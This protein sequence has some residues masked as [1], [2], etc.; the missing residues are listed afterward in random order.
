M[1]RPNFLVIVGGDAGYVLDFSKS[2]PTSSLWALTPST[3]FRDSLVDTAL[4]I[5]RIGAGCDVL[6][7]DIHDCLCEHSGCWWCRRRPGRLSSTPLPS[8]AGLPYSGRNPRVRFHVP[9]SR[10]RLVMW[11]APNF[12]SMITLRPLGPRVTFT[13]SASASTP[14][15]SSSRAGI[16]FYFFCHGFKSSFYFQPITARTSLWRIISDTSCLRVRSQFLHISRKEQCRLPE[17]H[18]LVLGAVSY[19]KHFPLKG[20]LFRRV[21]DV[22]SGKRF[23]LPPRWARS[24]ARSANRSDIHTA[25]YNLRFYCDFLFLLFYSGAVSVLS[26]SDSGPL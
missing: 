8:R 15:F 22:D 21:R 13:A 23:F 20:F 4:K 19:G 17:D 24:A 26:M 10:R 3:T 7:S 5:H 14:F 11:G 2:S 12:F 25:E 16:E 6:E 9:P 18:F 1:R